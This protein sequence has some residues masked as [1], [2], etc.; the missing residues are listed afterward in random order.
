[1]SAL[2][3]QAG[4][5]VVETTKIVADAFNEEIVKLQSRCNAAEDSL[6][7][8]LDLCEDPDAVHANMLRGVIAK[9]TWSQIL[10]VYPEE[11]IAAESRL[12]EVT[13]E[14]ARLREALERVVI[15]RIARE[16]FVMHGPA[17]ALQ[18]TEQM[19]SI[20]ERALAR[21]T[22]KTETGQ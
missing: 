21:A 10:H 5:S 8:V 1:M 19:A 6:A 11:A 16:E 20:A 3:T 13:G 15:L 7:G 9:P 18:R 17:F 4:R 14:N 2:E 22:I 12:A